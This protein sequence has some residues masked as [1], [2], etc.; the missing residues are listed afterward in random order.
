MEWILQLHPP[1]Y[2]PSLDG[3]LVHHG[4]AHQYVAIKHKIQDLCVCVCVGGGGGG[5][6]RKTKQFLAK[7]NQVMEQNQPPPP[8]SPIQCLM[9]WLSLHQDLE[10]LVKPQI[11]QLE[12]EDSK[13]NRSLLD[14]HYFKTTNRWSIFWLTSNSLDITGIL[15]TF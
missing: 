6:E 12:V 7:E 3:M 15:K 1:P 13:K 14:K 9:W 2:R 8:P 5:G 11:L 4:I 10:K